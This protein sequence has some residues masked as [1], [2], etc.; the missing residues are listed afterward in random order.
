[1]IHIEDSMREREKRPFACLVWSINEELLYPWKKV[2]WLLVWI[3][4]L[5]E[6]RQRKVHDM[7]NSID[8]SSA[9][10]ANKK[11]FN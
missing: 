9:N 5:I 10:K 2:Y 4:K 1:M 6:S 8:S 7:Y 11:K 3:K